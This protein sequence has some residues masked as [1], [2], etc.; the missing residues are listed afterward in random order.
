MISFVDIAFI[1][2]TAVIVFAG[3]KRGLV[4][5]LASMLR[6]ILIV[7][8]SLVAS[9]YLEPYVRDKISQDIPKTLFSVLL[10]VACLVLLAILTGILLIVLKKLQ[11]KKDMPFHAT[12]SVLGG[13]F[14][15]IKALVVVITLAG[16]CSVAVG[17]IPKDNEFYTAIKGSYAVNFISSFNLNKLL[18][19]I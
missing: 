9:K 14:G 11:K 10:F 4:V 12:N 2:I 15:F 6:F 19:V 13:V 5:S 16:I 17:F 3:I 7:P 18:E 1:A 8:V